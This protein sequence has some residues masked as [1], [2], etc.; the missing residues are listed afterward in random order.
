MVMAGIVTNRA[1]V[2]VGRRVADDVA[3]HLR[4][5]AAGV[6]VGVWQQAHQRDREGGHD[7]GDARGP[8]KRHDV[9]S[10]SALAG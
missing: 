4:A 5:S 9:A 3:M 1:G 8:G 7:C 2:A 10:M 6:H